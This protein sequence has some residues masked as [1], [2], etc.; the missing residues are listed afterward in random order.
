MNFYHGKKF[1]MLSALG[2]WPDLFYYRYLPF[3]MCCLGNLKYLA[4]TYTC[5]GYIAVVTE[6]RPF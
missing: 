6:I 4:L 2:I 1:F 5:L 3:S